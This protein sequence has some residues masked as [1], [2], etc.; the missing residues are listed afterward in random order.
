M[1]VL[2]AGPAARADRPAT[3]ILHDESSARIVAFHLQRGQKVKPHR[4]DSTVFVQVVSG[5]GWFAG[6]NA[7]EYLTAGVGAVYAPGELHS[8]D[9]TE[10]PLRF[11]AIITPRPGG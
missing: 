4:S 5:G 8:I 1:K 2:S 6:E 9:A 10:T 7:R 11:L 3:E